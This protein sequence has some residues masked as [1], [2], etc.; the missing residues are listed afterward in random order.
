[1]RGALAG[2]ELL[3]KRRF[4]AT[5]PVSPQKD[6]FCNLSLPFSY[7]FDH[8]VWPDKAATVDLPDGLAVK[9]AVSE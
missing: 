8:P 1:M 4:A 9:A 3:P 5:K 7:P 6:G 2:A